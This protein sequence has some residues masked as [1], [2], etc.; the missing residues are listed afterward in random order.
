MVFERVGGVVGGAERA[1][2]EA[3]EQTL[4]AI[5]MGGQALVGLFPNAR[6]ATF[7]QKFG[8]VEVARQF[9]VSPVVERVTQG[10]RDGFGPGE[11][12]IAGSGISSAKALIDAVGAHGPPLVVVAFEPDFEEVGELTVVG[13][14]ARGEM[15]VVVENRFLRS[16]LMVQSARSGTLQQKVV[17]NE[18]HNWY[19]KSL[20]IGDEGLVSHIELN[21]DHNSINFGP[22]SIIS[23]VSSIFHWEKMDL[24]GRV[25]CESNHRWIDED[26][27]LRDTTGADCI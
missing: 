15:V 27:C 8:D 12:F 1:H 25:V 13:D 2:F 24:M 11:E 23:G 5:L 16:V 7:I 20:N 3:L 10:L 26:W 6:S 4:S 18:G 9:E 22:Y 21:M 19:F 14:V 17:M